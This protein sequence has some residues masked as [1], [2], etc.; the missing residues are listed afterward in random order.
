MKNIIELR[1]E[2]IE[3]FDSLKSNKM[4]YKKAKE[5]NHSAG[6][7]M[8]SLK[9]QMEYSKLHKKKVKIEFMDS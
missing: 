3:V 5:L 6:K 7:I 1:N 9:M 2:I 4:D 8:T